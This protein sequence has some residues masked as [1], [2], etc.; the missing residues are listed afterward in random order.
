MSFFHD[1]FSATYMLGV[2][3]ELH[4]YCFWPA[5]RSTHFLVILS[6]DELI[7]YDRDRQYPKLHYI[8]N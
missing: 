3:A 4:E 8:L 5:Y 6:Y 1:S 2:L 7:S